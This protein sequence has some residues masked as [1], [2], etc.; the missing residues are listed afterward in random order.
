MF[1]KRGAYILDTYVLPPLA[2]Q[3][4]RDEQIKESLRFLIKKEKPAPR[5]TTPKVEEPPE[6]S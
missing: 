4:L 3:A 1:I 2:P 5:P 6:V